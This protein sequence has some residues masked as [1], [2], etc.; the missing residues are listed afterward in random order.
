MLVADPRRTFFLE[1]DLLCSTHSC[2]YFFSIKL[3]PLQKFGYLKRSPMKSIPSKTN[4][5]HTIIRLLIKYP[6]HSYS[7]PDR[8]LLHDQLMPGRNCNTVF[9]NKKTGV[10]KDEDRTSQVHIQLHSYSSGECFMLFRDFQVSR[11]SV[12]KCQVLIDIL[13][14]LSRPA[15]IPYSHLCSLFFSNKNWNKTSHNSSMPT[16][17]QLHFAGLLFR[18]HR[19]HL[20]DPVGLRAFSHLKC[21]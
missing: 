17:S 2:K 20:L 11:V 3:N 9:R 5:S 19:G 12:K 1:L 10:G 4:G 15:S 14:I 18:Q 13:C 21:I 8:I 16:L 7:F 6:T